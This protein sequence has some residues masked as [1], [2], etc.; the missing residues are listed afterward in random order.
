VVA[1]STPSTAAAAGKTTIQSAEGGGGASPFELQGNNRTPATSSA[2]YGQHQQV[3]VRQMQRGQFQNGGRGWPH[4]QQQQMPRP[5]SAEVTTLLQQQQ[6]Q[7]QQQTMMRHR[8]S[9]HQLPAERR[10]PDAYGRF[11]TEY[12]DVYNNSSTASS[13][14][15]PQMLP[16][17]SSP[18]AASSSKAFVVAHRSEVARRVPPRPH[19]V[20]FLQYPT[21]PSTPPLQQQPSD[22]LSSEQKYAQQVRQSVM[23]NYPRE[24]Q[25]ADNVQLAPK[26]SEQPSTPQQQQQLQQQQHQRRVVRDPAEISRDVKESALWSYVQAAGQPHL[27]GAHHRP[28]GKTI[29]SASQENLMAEESL[30]LYRTGHEGHQQQQP[31]QQQPQLFHRSASA[32]LPKMAKQQPD[33]LNSSLADHPLEMDNKRIEQVL[34]ISI[35]PVFHI[36]FDNEKLFVTSGYDFLNFLFLFQREESMKRLL[37][38]KQRML[39]SPL[40]RKS[41]NS[42]VSGGSGARSSERSTPTLADRDAPSPRM[43]IDS[44]LLHPQQQQ[45]QQQL[46]QQP[47]KLFFTSSALLRRGG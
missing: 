34:S 25:P 4:Q 32:R 45:Q 2:M 28:P 31:Q 11:K 38:W 26:E 17:G 6:Q 15:S 47:S 22:Y 36:I 20:D 33:L 16:A 18:A 5:V 39:Q 21:I 1:S 44:P 23:R 43:R 41:G 30:A 19:S 24:Q 12:E 37:E 27:S 46:H 35:H 13:T 7:S 3:A 8:N 14:N 9:P 42:V 10:T 40:T 29:L